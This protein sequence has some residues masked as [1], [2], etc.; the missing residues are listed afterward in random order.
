MNYYFFCIQLII[1][2]CQKI[3]EKDFI[4][5]NIIAIKW[6]ESTHFPGRTGNWGETTRIHTQGLGASEKI[7]NTL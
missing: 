1:N 3:V 6:G 2:N 7:K 5:Y 4:Y